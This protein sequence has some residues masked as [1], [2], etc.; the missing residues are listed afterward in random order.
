MHCARFCAFIYAI[1]IRIVLSNN[2]MFLSITM[3]LF[4]FNQVLIC[5]DCQ[6]L[7]FKISSRLKSSEELMFYVVSV[8]ICFRL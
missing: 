1:R 8:Y 7:D 5:Y 4:M 6:L 3:I 2:Y